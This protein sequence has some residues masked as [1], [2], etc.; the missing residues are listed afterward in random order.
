MR[1]CHP[2][3]F[4]VALALQSAPAAAVDVELV[5]D[6]RVQAADAA[7]SFLQGGLGKLRADDD[8]SIATSRLRL[9]L[10]QP[11]G[12]TWRAVLDAT[13]SADD[14]DGSSDVT[15]AFLEYR[16]YPSEGWRTRVK[17]GAFYA[18]ISLE[19]RSSGW[20]TPY[21]LSS[22]AVN[23]WIGE[24]V[25][26]LGAE[27]QLDWLGTRMGRAFDAGLVAGVH[28]WNDFAGAY[29][30]ARGFRVQDRQTAIFGVV[31][32][33]GLK[34]YSREPFLESDDRPGY[35]LGVR[36][37]YANRLELRALH[38]DN[39][40]DGTVYVSRVDDFIWH[41]R[42]DAIGLR[43]ETSNGWT[44]IA[45][46]LS[47]D[48]A[49]AP[50]GFLI[51]WDYDASF[52]LLSREVG[53]RHRISARYDDFSL[54]RRNPGYAPS[55]S[56]KGDAWTLAWLYEPRPDWRLAAEWQRI[57]GEVSKRQLLLGEAPGLTETRLE[58]SLR[59]TFRNH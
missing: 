57:H 46:R 23:A 7:P 4:A 22:S 10:A 2:L 43:L 35:Y 38:Y 31:A 44:V 41:T 16:P 39:R 26:T 59:R 13:F 54:G 21:S 32:E 24:E 33:P 15:E 37:H 27:V 19:N 18:P 53:P 6:L 28:G 8:L 48:T 14:P 51:L 30:A 11:L 9:G 40:G 58:L 45:Q 29:L 17:V 34:A 47:G 12:E 5:A 3:L 56:D 20:E 49:I 25:R 42:F 52:A 36:W 55:N 50:G 1:R